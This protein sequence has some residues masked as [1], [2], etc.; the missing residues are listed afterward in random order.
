MDREFLRELLVY[1][2]QQRSQLDDSQRLLD[3][4]EKSQEIPP[5]THITVTT[6]H[7]DDDDDDEQVCVSMFL[8]D[9]QC[10][11]MCLYYDCVCLSLCVRC[12][13]L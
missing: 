9:V 8:C 4:L 10:V 7:D 6:T 1:L 5:V 11:C 2:Q 13:C 12:V 3:R